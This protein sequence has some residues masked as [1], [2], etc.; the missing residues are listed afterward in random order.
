M[1]SRWLSAADVAA[2]LGTGEVTA[3]VERATD[4]S[5]SQVERWRPEL[6][7]T[8]TFPTRP[9]QIPPDVY[10]GALRYATLLHDSGNTPE[11]FA[12]FDQAGGILIPDSSKMTEVYRLVGARRPKVG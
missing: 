7:P 10:L 6:F 5:M 8:A 9:D 11:G 4:A 1:S 3:E 12:G 2:S